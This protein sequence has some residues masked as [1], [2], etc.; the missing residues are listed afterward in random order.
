[1]KILV[2][3]QPYKEILWSLGLENTFIWGLLLLNDFS[4]AWFVFAIATLEIVLPKHTWKMI[5]SSKP[6]FVF[7]KTKIN[8]TLISHPS[9]KRWCTTTSNGL[10]KSINLLWTNYLLARNSLLGS[11]VQLLIYPSYVQCKR[12]YVRMLIEYNAWNK[13]K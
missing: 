10:L 4:F 1:M 6:Y 13:D 8:Q 9:I 2:H 12:C 5:I 3:Q 7:I 11:S